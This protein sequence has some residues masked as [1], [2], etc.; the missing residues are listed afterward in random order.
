MKS[1]LP[2]SVLTAPRIDEL[3]LQLIDRNPSRLLLSS[4][5]GRVIVVF[6]FGI[7]CGTCKRLANLL[8]E[9]RDEFKPDVEFIGVCIQSD[10]EERLE[11]FGAGSSTQ[12][13]LT[14]CPSRQLRPAF[15]IPSG[16][17]LFYPTLIFIDNKQRMRGYFV[18]G[19]SF[20]ED[21]PA[22]LRRVLEELLRERKE[23]RS[24]EIHENIE[25]GA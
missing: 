23:G 21:T 5:A 3:A 12:L 19:D 20:F 24:L 2:N 25:V 8:S 1:S 6:I 13:T 10:C 7:D 14:Y 9:F 15:H 16:T 11:A 4:L 18:G 22:N 17:W